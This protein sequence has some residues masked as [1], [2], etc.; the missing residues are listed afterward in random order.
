MSLNRPQPPRSLCLRERSLRHFFFT[1]AHIREDR[2]SVHPSHNR[3]ADGSM[4]A[5]DVASG[6]G[7]YLAL[8]LTS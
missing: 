5:G 2:F 4:D 7:T 1:R 6:T 8:I 3:S